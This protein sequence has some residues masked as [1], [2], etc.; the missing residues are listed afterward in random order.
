MGTYLGLFNC[1]ICL[2][3]LVIS[4]LGG[5]ILKSF[6]DNQVNMIS[7]AGILL[8]LGTIAVFIIPAKKKVISD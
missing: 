1:T 2:P 4:G 6:E 3:Q 5:H 7:L 8:I